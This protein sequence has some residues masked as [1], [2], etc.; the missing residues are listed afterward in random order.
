[1]E[2]L[3]IVTNEP[4]S[5]T[6]AYALIKILSGKYQQKRF[7]VLVNSA[8]SKEEADQ[9]FRNLSMVSD[10]YLASPSLDYLGWIPYDEKVSNAV[11]KQKTVLRLY[12]NAASSKGFMKLAK[13][14]ISNWEKTAFEGDLKFF[15]RT[16][17]DN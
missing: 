5:L 14:L 13:L 3:V 9:I 6:D 8:R 2:R 11:K 10:R 16:L 1:M 15:W 7:M 4:T 17:L 12:P